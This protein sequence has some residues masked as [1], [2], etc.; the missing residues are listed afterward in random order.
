[1]LIIGIAARERAGRPAGQEVQP[2]KI[3]RAGQQS[4]GA[5]SRRTNNG[6]NE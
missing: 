2:K 4:R 6:D 1:M 3:T 5:E